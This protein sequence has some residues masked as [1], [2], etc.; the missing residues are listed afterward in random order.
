M[1]KLNTC[2][3]DLVKIFKE[4]IAVMD[5]TIIEG[6]RSTE[7]QEEYVRTGKSKTRLSKHLKQADGYAHAVDCGVFIKG[8]VE[9]DDLR[10]YY[11]LGGIVKAIAD[12]F[13]I[14]IRWGGDWDSDGDFSDQTFNDLVH[15]ELI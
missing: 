3:P 6:V 2:H 4:V 14:K 10:Y 8:R 15:F 12:D 1:Q 13:G 11:Y 9:W 7:T 5:C